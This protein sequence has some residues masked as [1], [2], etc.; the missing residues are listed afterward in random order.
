MKG[1]DL[2]SGQSDKRDIQRG[3]CI[4]PRLLDM[5]KRRRP[6]DIR[7]LL[8]QRADRCNA[9]RIGD[10]SLGHQ[11]INLTRL[12]FVQLRPSC[13]GGFQLFTNGNQAIQHGLDDGLVTRV[14]RRIA[15]LRGEFGLLGF[16]GVDQTR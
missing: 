6:P 8:E 16:K 11:V 9:L 13:I 1:F 15:A 7:G 2:I 10:W 5:M 3:I 12:H 14:E 4:G